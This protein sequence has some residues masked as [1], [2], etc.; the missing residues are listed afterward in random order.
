MKNPC[1]KS[2]YLEQEVEK[3]NDFSIDLIID[4]TYT[5]HELWMN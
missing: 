2:I 4:Q 3:R 5:S 1:S